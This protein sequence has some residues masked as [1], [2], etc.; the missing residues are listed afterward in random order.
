LGN[1]YIQGF[2]SY[3]LS[4]HSIQL[5]TEIGNSRLIYKKMQLYKP[6]SKI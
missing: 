6:D 2:L 1:G 3:H 5:K 4:I